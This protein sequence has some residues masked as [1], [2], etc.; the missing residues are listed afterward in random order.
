MLRRKGWQG[1]GFCVLC[2]RASEDIH[3]LLIHCIFAQDIWKRTL[4]HFSLPFHWTDATFTECFS[5][6]FSAQAAPPSLAIFVSWQIWLER[7]KVLFEDASPSLQAV[8][9]RMLASFHWQP[10][11]VKTLPFKAVDSFLPEGYS[12]ACFDGA[13]LSSGS[14]C[15]AGGTFK[16]HPERITKW[17]LNCGRGSN[18]K[19]EL[20]GLWATLMIASSWSLNHLHVI[21]DS[22][23]IIDWINRKCRLQSI[24][25]EGWK[26]KTQQLAFS[27][28]DITFRHLPRSFNSEADALSKRALKQVVGRLSI[29]HCDRGLESPTSSFNL[30]EC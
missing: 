4:Q 12:V 29:F 5:S 15:G 6:W 28:S 11:T 19:A 8:F 27:F 14:C 18:T 3:H 9:Y 22:K 17:F 13:T 26:L 20:L 1:P 30:F 21:G 2:R 24:H 25:V 16:S 10:S 7:N 23:V